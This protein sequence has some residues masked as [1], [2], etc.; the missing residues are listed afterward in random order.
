MLINIS[1][2]NSEKWSSEQKAAAEKEWGKI[3]DIQFPSVNPHISDEALDNLVEIYENE[4]YEKLNPTQ[5][6]DCN[7]VH[8]MGEMTFVY[9]LVKAL[10]N[11]GIHC[12]AS[13]TER[14][15][16]EQDGVK[17]SIFKFVKFR[18]Y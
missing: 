3:F 2:H 9:R 16:S 4:V 5:G 15:V 10:Q 8:V 12:V 13:T 11:Q 1:N 18:S 6:V 7:A 14:I 17:T